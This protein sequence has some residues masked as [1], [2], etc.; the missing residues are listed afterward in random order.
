MKFETVDRFDK[1]VK[2]L[3]KKYNL[4]KQ[5][6]EN[7]ILNFNDIHT[8]ATN[9]TNNLYKIRLSNSN[10]NKG[11]SSGYRLYYYIK[12]DEYVYLLSIYD[13][14][15]MQNIDEKLLTKYINEILEFS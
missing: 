1:E 3:S 13:K 2:K 7:F 9:I 6:L 5:D 11:K 8:K 4:I 15:Q 10:K 12:I 14:S